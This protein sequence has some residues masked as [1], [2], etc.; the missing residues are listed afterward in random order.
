[1]LTEEQ[2]ENLLAV[3]F[4][5]CLLAII[6]IASFAPPAGALSID[7]IIVSPNTTA[8]AGQIVTA[9]FN[10]SFTPTSLYTT[11]PKTSV[12][13]STDLESPQWTWQLTVEGIK[14]QQVTE[15]ENPLI[16]NGWQFAY[17]L[18]TSEQFH[19]TLSGKAP[20]ITRSQVKTVFSATDYDASGLGIS[21]T[22]VPISLLIIDP[23]DISYI[24][25]EEKKQLDQLRKHIDSASKIN[26]PNARGESTVEQLYTQAETG[27]TY[28]N[29]L[30]P[31][32]YDRA[33]TRSQEIQKAITDA[34]DQLSRDAAQN[35]I[36]IAAVPI[37]H[38]A[39]IVSW[40]TSTNQTGYSGFQNIS[41]RYNQSRQLFDASIQAMNVK[42]WAE[43]GSS[44]VKAYDLANQTLNDA[45]LLQ[46]RAMDPTTPIRENYLWVTAILII[47]GIAYL[48]FG[49][50][51][52]KKPIVAMTG[53]P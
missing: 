2:K 17:P 6:I 3:F 44:A 30:Y 11:D 51:R 4:T 15:T 53:K 23:S 40:F 39:V 37:N 13:I 52:K 25:T 32:E 5:A 48:F 8:M 42:D 34:E 49:R 43:A 45:Q 10:V 27:I 35:Q 9:E 33:V 31:E 47:M 50:K 14:G 20:G 19:V 41:E 24:R 12:R 1:M 7:N 18:G 28:L 38:T 21:G 29:T 22:T 46:G 26:A 16:L 36:N